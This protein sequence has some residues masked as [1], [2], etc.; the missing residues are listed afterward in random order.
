MFPFKKVYNALQINSSSS[1]QSTKRPDSISIPLRQLS[2]R[3]VSEDDN[4]DVDRHVVQQRKAPTLPVDVWFL[5][6]PQVDYTENCTLCK[7]KQLYTLSLV[8]RVFNEFATKALYQTLD[9]RLEDACLEV[10]GDSLDSFNNE[11]SFLRENILRKKLDRLESTL[12][13]PE[14]PAV[15][16]RHLKFP[17]IE[18][19]WKMTY[20]PNDINPALYTGLS[21][22]VY[23]YGRDEPSAHYRPKVS[24]HDESQ[25]YVR[26]VMRRTDLALWKNNISVGILPKWI[27]IF[28]LASA[29]LESVFG[30]GSLWTY[31][32]E[33]ERDLLRERLFDAIEKNQNWVEWDWRW[34]SWGYSQRSAEAILEEP[35][36]LDIFSKMKNIRSIQLDKTEWA[37]KVLE[38]FPGT[39]EFVTI[40][41]LRIGGCD[42]DFM[43][44][45]L[46]TKGLKSLKIVVS[47]SYFK[48]L[49]KC[50]PFKPL[51]EYLKLCHQ[52][53]TA[54][55]T[56]LDFQVNW[57]LS[58][59]SYKLC[60]D[61]EGTYLGMMPIEEFLSSIFIYAPLLRTFNFVLATTHEDEVQ[62]PPTEKPMPFVAHNLRSMS[63][64]LPARNNKI[65]FATKISSGAFPALR[66]FTF[67]SAFSRNNG[68]KQTCTRCVRLEW[69]EINK[70]YDFA[71]EQDNLLVEA[72][73]KARVR[74]WEMEVMNRPWAECSSFTLEES[75]GGGP[76][77]L[78]FRPP[79]KHLTDYDAGLFFSGQSG[80]A[81]PRRNSPK[82]RNARAIV[83]FVP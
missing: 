30:L 14:G 77:N 41:S 26:P 9:L 35:R 46:P 56:N 34:S 31:I 23:N 22:G 74:Q 7:H 69:P 75:C 72:C 63:I 61:L 24:T 6:L 3:T 60:N 47:E 79:Q 80:P 65:W 42:F 12:R 50:D 21:R 44:K 20:G 59:A 27:T 19:R 10:H 5:I 2:I 29:R 37:D 54:T 62:Y 18:L 55:L 52:Q 64:S 1:K 81:L 70:W 73:R 25:L 16:I 4:E 17:E 15:L 49:E 58:S 40:E 38:I 82:R 33:Y 48:P 11:P 39:L 71:S 51:L 43:L 32:H 28:E 67:R 78:Y 45:R 53:S 8:C 57:N 36:M 13:S 68:P 76:G 66:K 83:K